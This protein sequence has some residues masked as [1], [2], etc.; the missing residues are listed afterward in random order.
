M[1]GIWYVLLDVCYAHVHVH[2]IP[3]QRGTCPRSQGSSTAVGLSRAANA[4]AASRSTALA[5]SCMWY[6]PS[7][8]ADRHGTILIDTGLHGMS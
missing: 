5:R 8:R 2:T 4:A 1:L 6:T 3:Y 7:E